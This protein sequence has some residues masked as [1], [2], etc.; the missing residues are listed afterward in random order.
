MS[1][2]KGWYTEMRKTALILIVVMVTL[3]MASSCLSLFAEPIV[4]Q[5][6]PAAEATPTAEEG[7][8]VIPKSILIGIVVGAVVLGSAD[9]YYYA[10]KRK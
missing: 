5:T 2:L 7:G 4:P 9:G 6:T 8:V 10:R 1:V 3:F